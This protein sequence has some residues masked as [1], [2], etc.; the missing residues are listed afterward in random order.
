MN[1]FTL[2][3]SPL[4]PADARLQRDHSGGRVLDTSDHAQ[5]RRFALWTWK[6]IRP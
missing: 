1:G 6:A 3:E 4:D 2:T 5:G